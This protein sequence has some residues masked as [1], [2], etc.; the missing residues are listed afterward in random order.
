M[1]VCARARV[2]TLACLLT[3]G[4]VNASQH[5]IPW[6]DSQ[7]VLLSVWS[8]ICSCVG[9]ISV[10]WFPPA[11]HKHMCRQNGY[12]LWF[13]PRYECVCVRMLPCGMSSLHCAFLGYSLDPP[14][15]WP[16]VTEDKWMN[17]HMMVLK[18]KWVVTCYW[19]SCESQT[20]HVSS[21]HPACTGTD[22]TWAHTQL[23]PAESR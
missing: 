8:F 9:F 11:V 17:C 2:C 12:S 3:L 16:E 5:Q 21:A 20:F 23:R 6:I 4:N 18:E 15:P 1:H 7:L 10:L 19:M 13:F 22:Q 14:W